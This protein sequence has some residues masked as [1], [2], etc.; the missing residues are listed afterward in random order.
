MEIKD[1]IA[2]VKEYNKTLPIDKSNFERALYKNTQEA[3]YYIYFDRITG[4]QYVDNDPEV[5]L[6]KHHHF[7]KILKNTSYLLDIY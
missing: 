6:K 7:S 5:F 4:P 1:L 2:R 3:N